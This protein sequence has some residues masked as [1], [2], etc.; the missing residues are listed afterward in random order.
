MVRIPFW[1]RRDGNAFP[2]REALSVRC[3]SDAMVLARQDVPRRV[4]EESGTTQVDE[5]DLLFQQLVDEQ[6]AESAGS[7]WRIPWPAVYQLL[8]D[9]DFTSV[10]E[11]LGFPSAAFHRPVIASR[12][13][14]TDGNFAI[15]L[16]GWLEPD[17][18]PVRGDVPVS[19][20]AIKV[21]G[22]T[23]LMRSTCWNLVDAISGM[24]R[25]QADAPSSTA[26]ANR[27][28]WA[29]IR[30]LAVAAG[31]EMSDFLARTVVLAPER[32]EIGLR[33]VSV[34]GARVVEV[35][36]GFQEQPPR[37]LEFFDRGSDVPDRYEI[38]DGLGLTH[39]IVP[40][41][42][43]TVLR[44]IK[45]MPGRRVAGDRAE[46]FLRNPF[47]LLGPDAG[48]VLVPEQFEQ[49]RIEAGVEFTRF[50]G[51]LRHDDRGN[52]LAAGLRLE[53]M[54]GGSVE[55]EVWFASSEEILDFVDLL[56]ARIARG[57]EMCAWRGHDLEIL[58]DTPDESVML[59][60]AAESIRSRRFPDAREVLDLSGYSD[61]I[62]SIG[63]E[64]VR[65]S[66]FVARKSLAGGWIPEN[67]EGGWTFLG[68]P[69]TGDATISITPAIRA[70]I[71]GAIATAKT[72]GGTSISLPEFPRPVPVDWAEAALQS[73]DAAVSRLAPNPEATDKS[74]KAESTE[75]KRLVV[76]TNVESLDYVERRGEL[77]SVPL[78]APALPATL[79][80][81]VSLKE[82]QVHGFGWLS[83][84][85]ASSP[86]LCRGA[87]LADDMG[88]GKTLQL[89]VFI[90][91]VQSREPQL[92]PV[93]I[94]APVSLL[95]NWQEEIDR[96]FVGGTFRVLTLYGKSLASR[97]VPKASLDAELT[98]GG[99]TRLL[100]RDWIGDANVVLTTYETLRDLEFSLARQKWSVVICDEAQKIK[101]PAA[102][103]TRSA[104]KQQ[105]RFR[106]ACTGTPV[107]N[108]L[109]DIW[110][111]YNFI[112]PGLLGTERHFADTY[113]KPIEAETQEEKS[114]IESLRALI[115]PQK[116][117]RT[118]LE[119]ARELPRKIEVE[120]CRS[121]A[122]SPLQRLLYAG[123]VSE[124]RRNSDATELSNVHHLSLLH[125]LR[126]ICS[127]PMPTSVAGGTPM[128]TVA[129][130]LECSPKM[131][132]L[133]RTLARIKV[134]REK[135]IV[136]CEFRD[137][138]RLLQLVISQKLDT[139]P[140]VING[141]TSVVAG[142]TDNRHGRIRRF[143]EASGFGVIILSPLAVGFGVNVQSANH[144]VHF[145]R[146]WN[147]AKED[148]ATD[149]AYRIG[150]TR[151]V[152]VYYP[153]V[154]A[155]D[156]VTFDAKLDRLLEWKRDLS[157]DM[158]NGVGDVAM[159]DFT[160]LEAPDGGR[161]FLSA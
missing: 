50:R 26:E 59:R 23:R 91:S 110:S 144:V 124:F 56:D 89:L 36:P 88:L 66:P 117:R 106:I 146:M 87:L 14:L 140:D 75:Q 101:N 13:S 71:A 24:H 38:P 9:P 47:S 62:E 30:S 10:S 145:T 77:V 119:V 43:R 78:A 73:M 58:G 72:S 160:D 40:P 100:H 139:L 133:V 153:L 157:R 42:V 68:E 135:A 154:V 67:I 104:W 98:Q 151:E 16:A 84:L 82:H 33:S 39:V 65:V 76:K 107:E 156:F 121:L 17:G 18:T 35:S 79:R 123:A 41:E 49:A 116:L 32:L 111:L 127:N 6:L 12:G 45:R 63:F 27:A 11:L 92:E 29:R 15:L 85:W 28:A 149:R 2:T 141:D 112:Q 147:P 51:V 8:E 70:A 52:V 134:N 108:S 61:R 83:H 60:A 105:A 96:F 93:L 37:W 64:T 150:Q 69:G 158:L 90:A 81:G 159:S 109:V 137:L 1:H 115:E 120:E 5:R 53:S 54:G 7:E 125:R 152:H 46:A 55:E 114:R 74:P 130:A 4:A 118:K 155:D 97:R 102:M 148:Q 122:L 31:A 86:D 25:L 34:S 19:G 132:W 143:Q 48:T 57:A 80:A 138:Q 95:E 3:E 129:A 128:A 142:R 103:V 94:V 20:G 126:M 113:R 131:S 161:V 99:I 21:G 22:A 44:E 136:F